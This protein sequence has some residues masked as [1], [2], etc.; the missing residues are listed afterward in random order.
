MLGSML[1]QTIPQIPQIYLTPTHT[2]RKM[3]GNRTRDPGIF[4]NI[5]EITQYPANIELNDQHQI[6]E[7]VGLKKTHFIAFLIKPMT[8]I[9]SQV[10][11]L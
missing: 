2:R 7:N 6:N 10:L 3:L 11:L 5:Y 9:K 8:V 4:E 1:H